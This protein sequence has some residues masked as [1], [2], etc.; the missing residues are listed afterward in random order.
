M[1]TTICPRFLERKEKKTENAIVFLVKYGTQFDLILRKFMKNMEFSRLDN[2]HFYH[3]KA[4]QNVKNPLLQ[5][6]SVSFKKL[7]KLLVSGDIWSKSG[8][9]TRAATWCV[10][11]SVSFCPLLLFR[12]CVH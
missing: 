7:V 1:C 4:C 6:S 2:R 8:F 10:E 9:L 3:F 12:Y 11:L 5:N